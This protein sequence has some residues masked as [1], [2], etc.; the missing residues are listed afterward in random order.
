MG[1]L[2]WL[3][4]KTP[5][6]KDLK[7]GKFDDNYRWNWFTS[8]RRNEKGEYNLVKKHPIFIHHSSTMNK[9]MDEFKNEVKL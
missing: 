9:T 8:F 2:W 5:K 3:V 4:N 6:Y 1:S 7:L